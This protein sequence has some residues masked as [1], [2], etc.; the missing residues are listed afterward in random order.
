[1]AYAIDIK[2]LDLSYGTNKVLEGVNLKIQVNTK[3]A[4][5]GAN[6]AG[7]STLIKAII[8]FA[9]KDKGEIKVFGKDIEDARSEIAYVPQKDS[10]NWDFPIKVFD[11]VLMGRYKKGGLFKKYTQ[12]D[13]EIAMKA[14]KQIGMQ[15]YKDKQIAHLS[16]GQK[17]RVFLARALCQDAEAYILDE[18]LTGVDIKT[19]DIIASEFDRL[20]KAGKTIICVHH[21]IYSLKKYFD[22][23]VVLNRNVKFH[24][25]I[26]T[27]D[28][29]KYIELGFRG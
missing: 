10:V 28:L 23:I 9:K 18:P 12:E 5:V 15:A 14:L 24:G 16:G 4:I 21:N 22:D 19:E 17:Q 3:T 1:M 29:G 11:V 6:G 20:K 13:R 7:K 2:D 8:G 25:S 27:D 26:D